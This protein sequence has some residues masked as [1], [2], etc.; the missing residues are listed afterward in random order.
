MKLKFSRVIRERICKTLTPNL[1]YI[2]IQTFE[3]QYVKVVQLNYDV[4]VSMSQWGLNGL[5]SS[6][7][8]LQVCV[9]CQISTNPI[10]VKGE[11]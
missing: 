3:C 4:Q 7:C 6:A 1:L 9:V 5:I 2:A 11:S 8:F 10:A